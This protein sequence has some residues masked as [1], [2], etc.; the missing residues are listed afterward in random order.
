M[1]DKYIGIKFYKT[2]LFRFTFSFFNI[3]LFYV[4]LF[5]DIINF[6]PSF[7]VTFTDFSSF[8]QSITLSLRL[9]TQFSKILVSLKNF[10]FQNLD[11]LAVR[12]EKMVPLVYQGTIY[13][14]Q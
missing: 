5:N 10:N 2:F 3:N 12:F 4:V 6:R 8:S 13:T 11:V 14:S 1:V 7:Y 9:R